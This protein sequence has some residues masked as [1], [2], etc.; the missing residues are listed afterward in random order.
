MPM[1]ENPAAYADEAQT[2]LRALAYTP[3]AIDGPRQ[4]YSVEG[5]L[6]SGRRVAEPV[7]AP[8]RGVP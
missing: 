2:A 6:T 4:I 3:R 5:S 1:F 8:A 7:V